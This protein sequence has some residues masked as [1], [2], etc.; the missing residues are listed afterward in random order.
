MERGSGGERERG[1][2]G[3]RE[4]GRGG[5]REREIERE[6]AASSVVPRVGTSFRGA[7]W[8]D[9]HIRVHDQQQDMSIPRRVASVSQH[10]DDGSDAGAVRSGG[11]TVR[12]SGQADA[13]RNCQIHGP[14]L[15]LVAEAPPTGRPELATVDGHA[16]AGQMCRPA[17]CGPAVADPTDMRTTMAAEGSSHN[18]NARS[19][20][21]ERGLEM[22]P[23]QP[24]TCLKDSHSLGTNTTVLAIS[25]RL[26]VVRPKPAI[27]SRWYGFGRSPQ[28]SQSAV[29]G[30][31]SESESN[32]R[33]DDSGNVVGPP[34]PSQIKGLPAALSAVADANANPY[35]A[36]SSQS[37]VAD[38]QHDP[39]VALDIVRFR[40]NRAHGMPDDYGCP[41]TRACG[42]GPTDEGGEEE[43]PVGGG[44]EYDD[45][46]VVTVTV[47][48]NQSAFADN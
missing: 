32:Q 48:G 8:A 31:S 7:F 41:F 38:S 42:V 16:V 39:D 46:D 13:Q 15:S 4:R 33:S 21:R 24:P 27:R 5:E 20:T 1:R 30:Q 26:E 23:S 29:A 45:A 22:H 35:A 17:V 10:D 9:W 43:V 40:Y 37:A 25:D 28:Q 47:V 14:V 18:R 2:V 19:R 12:S 3:E 34:L 44:E 6:G 11:Q 36:V